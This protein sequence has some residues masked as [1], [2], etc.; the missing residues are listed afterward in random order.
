MDV[1][2]LVVIGLMGSSIMAVGVTFAHRAAGP[3]DRERFDKLFAAGNFKDA[4]EGYRAL[5]LDAKAEPDR[6]GA[7]L[8]RA[9]QCLVQLGRVDEVDA[10]REAVVAVHPG[11]WRLSQAAAESY[12]NDAN[13]F[14]FIVAGKFH[15]GHLRGEGRYVGTYERD[16]SRALQLMVQGLDRVR[17]DPDRRAAGRYLLSLSEVLMGNRATSDSWRLQSL[18]PLDVLPDYEE[19]PF[20]SWGGQRSGAPVGPEGTPVYYRVPESFEKARNDGQRWRWALAQAA[21]AD[22]GLLNTTRIALANFLL[23]QFG[24]HTIAGV[25]FGGGSFDGRPE[26]SGPFALDT[27]GDDETIA[28]LASG[29]K[30]FK[31]PDEF[32]PIKIYQTIADDPK[33]ALGEEALHSLATIFENRRQFDRSALYLKRSRE[34]YGDGTGG[35][36]KQ[37]LDQI[38]N[39]WGQFDGLGTQPA[40]RGASVDFRFRNGRRVRFEAHEVLVGK[41]LKDVKE[42]I[43][44]TPAPLDWRRF[45]ISDIGARL[46][47][48]DEQKYL[49]SSVARWSL[50]L[51]PL[52]G[53][54]DKRITVTTPL[55]SAGAYLLTAR[56]EGGNTSRIVVWLDDTVILKKPLADGTYYFVADARTGQPIPRADVDLFGWQWQVDD[57]NKHRVDTKALSKKTDDDGQLQ[58]PVAEL[59]DPKGHYQWLIT[60]KTREGRFAHLGFTNIWAFGELDPAYDEVKV[61]TITDRPVYRP[62]APVR[63]KFWVARARHDQRDASDFAGKAFVVEIKNPKGDKVFNKSFTADAFGGFDGSLELPSDAMLGEYEVLTPNLGGGSFRVEEYKKPEFEVSVEAPTRP[64][65]LGEKVP[66]TIKAK[67]YFGGPVALAKVKY[68]ITRTRADERWYPAARWD[69]LFGPGYWWFAADSSWYPGWSRWGMQRPTPSWWGGAEAPPEVVAEAEL[70]IR[71]D[72]TLPLEIDTALAGLAHPDQDQ[73]YDI[74]AEVTDQS[75]RTIV[76]TGTVLVARKPFTVYTWV[77]RGHYRASEQIEAGIL[78][79]TLDRKPV[80]GKGTLKLLKIAYDAER[81]PMETPVETWDLALDPEGQARQVLRASAAGQYRLAATIDDGRGHVIEGGYLLTITGEGYRGASFRFNDLE[82]IP[83]RKEY[84]PGETLRLLINTN[85][86]NSTVLLFIR[87]ANGVYL[88]PKV[89]HLRDKSTVEEIGIASRDMPNMFVEALTVADGKVHNEVRE[90][91]IPPESRVVNIAIEPAQTTY[92]PGQK[93]KVKVKLTGPDGKP[94][95]GSTVLAVY[96]KAVE[97]ISGGSNVPEIKEFF[98]SWKRSHQPQTESS[99][100]RWFHNLTKPNEIA[101]RVLGILGWDPGVDGELAGIVM[102]RKKRVGLGRGSEISERSRGMGGGIGEMEQSAG[103]PASTVRAMAKAG[104][105]RWRMDMFGVEPPALSR[106]ADPYDGSAPPVQPVIRTNFADTAF[107]T[108]ALGTAPDGTAEVEFSLPE[109]LTTWKVK[110]WTMGLGTKVG[111]ADTEIVTTKDL[112]VRLQAPRFFVEKDEVVLSA[113]VHNK[114]K[115]QKA[116]RVVLELDGSVLHPLGETARTVL[117]AAG[118]E[119]RVDWRVKVAHEGQAIIRMKALTDEESDAAQ[120]SFP[121]YV[122][123]M[124]KME[125]FAG[126]IRP[127]EEKAQV[128]IRIAAER[129][130]DQSR[131]EVRYSPTLAGA[132]VDALPYLADYPYGCTEQTLNRFLPTVITQKV[133]INFGLHLKAIQAKH[134]NL[135]AQQLGDARER[136]KQWK[137]YEHNP[138]FDQPEVA[139]MAGAGIERLAVMQLSDGGWGWFSGYGEFSSGHTT[140]LVVHGLQVARQNDLRLPEGMLERGVA[141]L[142]SY[143][144]KQVRLLENGV[145]QVKPYKTSADDLDAMVFMVLTDAGV[146]NDR[147]LGLLDR[148][149]THLS[150]YAKAMFGL[151]LERIGEQSK[152]ALVLQNI[153]QYVVQDDENQTAYLKLPNERSWWWWYGSE[154]ET[155]AF[156]LKLLART[157]PR[158]KLASRLVKY[159][160]NNR[161]HGTYWNSTRDTAF[162]IEALA[163]YMKASGEDRPDMSVTIAFDGQT[164]KTVRITPADLFTF[165]NAFVLEGQ[166]LETGSH[167]V[168]LRKQGKGPLYFT[169]YLTNFTLEDPIAR[170]GLEIKVDRKVYRLVSDHK[171]VDVSGGRGQTVGQRVERYRREPL[172]EGA[173]LKSGE[174]V[175]VELEIDSKNDYEYL[176]FEDYKAAGFEPVEVRSGYNGNDLGAYVEFRDERVAFFARTLARGKHSVSYRLRA[177]IPGQ[178]H[179]LPARAQAM[180]APELRANSDEI[181]LRVED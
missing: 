59:A 174:L 107:W 96:D 23:N 129:R 102:K 122:H 180:Y 159:V 167:T 61:Y 44:S 77:D 153:G 138:V 148:D 162:C 43:S 37:R 78:A 90:I 124:L 175:E 75:R 17:S 101:M 9:I 163:E 25:D 20:S 65:M 123:G 11:N 109:S 104:E 13:H 26:A 168:S 29:I 62:G 1:R 177:E 36:K 24:T 132:L 51:D 42:Y 108:S 79:Q 15:R 67:Y 19:P 117:I 144:D 50:D 142:T 6:V 80:A 152:L 73:R 7:D 76:G 165:D 115:K 34:V 91:A 158:G 82:I 125:A 137:G 18:T 151:G 95:V 150:V 134:T 68:K 118:S 114:L 111:Q 105:A 81:R 35:W 141:W 54:F 147:M 136:A 173:I 100:D 130:P 131:L 32:N 113:N 97:Y 49:G 8:V 52:P 128:A 55:Q 31:L 56:M 169:A 10:F 74:N 83:E 160:L 86:V 106:F 47:T 154:I 63:F 72:G 87:P 156:Y 171:T 170:A 69:W 146:R 30:R 71:P 181:Q 178:F 46:V 157:D 112:L 179:T 12:R 139:K 2:R 57:K 58:V 40:G 53:H 85:Q 99:L 21:E 116:V 127:E 41:L 110:T 89:I 3:N 98:C 155:D 45:D 5:A 16:R 22:P 135:N 92:K 103:A 39:A 140:A 84:R 176:V 60:T 70:P 143:Q 33:T 119:H 164:R 88:P 93:A 66:A 48:G 149:R 94:F 28:R 161:K 166:A 38:L 27:L 145:S 133:L 126:A 64:V 4:Y 121:A 172:A 14:G 120:M